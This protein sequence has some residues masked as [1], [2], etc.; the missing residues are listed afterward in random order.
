MKGVAIIHPKLQTET[1]VQSIADTYPSSRQNKSIFMS[2]GQNW[3]SYWDLYHLH[4]VPWEICWLCVWGNGSENTDNFQNAC[5]EFQCLLLVLAN[6]A[7]LLGHTEC[8]TP[9]VKCVNLPSVRGL[10]IPLHTPPFPTHQQWVI[11][12]DSDIWRENANV[13][14]EVFRICKKIL[15][16]RPSKGNIATGYS[17]EK[18]EKNLRGRSSHY[19]CE[20]LLRI[21]KNISTSKLT[22]A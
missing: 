14:K 5:P 15:Y 17:K 10:Q 7:L 19:K 21:N 3:H 20:I 1:V 6:S 9:H 12:F 13:R 11:I 2:Y 4:K 18:Q 22:S 8:L 16:K